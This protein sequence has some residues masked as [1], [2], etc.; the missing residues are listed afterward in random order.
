MACA[1]DPR[2][3]QGSRNVVLSVFLLIVFFVSFYILYMSC[4]LLTWFSCFCVPFLL[5]DMFGVLVISALFHL[6]VVYSF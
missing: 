1:A 6:L 3:D 4:Y 5:Y 2:G